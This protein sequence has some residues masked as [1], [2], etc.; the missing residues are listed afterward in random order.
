MKKSDAKP[1]S[2]FHKNKSI[3]PGIDVMKDEEKSKEHLIAELEDMRK[4]IAAW[5]K[6]GEEG[7]GEEGPLQKSE[8]EFREFFMNSPIHRF[9]L[10]D[11]DLNIIAGNKI[12]LN[13]F[14]EIFG[15]ARECFTGKSF[16]DLIPGFRTSDRH[17]NYLKV[18]TTN[19][20][21]YTDELASPPIAG[22]LRLS[23]SV[24][25]A[26]DGLGIITTDITE[27]KIAEQA[28]RDS[29][30]KFRSL[31]F[32]IPGMVYRAFADWSAE[33]ISGS[34]EICGYTVKELNTKREK[35]LEVIHPEDREKVFRE[36]AELIKK[37]MHLA[38][39]YRI[40]T[41]EGDIR[42]VEDIKTSHFSD[43]GEFEA[44]DGIVLNITQRQLAEKTLKD[45]E[46][47][48]RAL[49][50][51]S[52]D[53]IFLADPGTGLILDANP[54]AEELLSLPH[55][56][57]VG[58]HQHQ[59]HPPELMTLAKDIFSRIALEADLEN[60]TE[61]IVQCANGEKKP[62]EILAQ[63]IQIDGKP[64]VYS[65]YRDITVRKQMEEEL[66]KAQRIKSLGTLAGGIAH[67]FNNVLTA[68][69]ANIS[70]ARI[71][72]DLPNDISEVLA[73]AEKASLQAKKLTQQLLSFA[74]GGAPIKKTMSISDL[75]RDT[76]AFSLSGSNVRHEFSLPE[77]LWPVDIDEGQIGQV[78]QNLTINADQAMPDGGLV[79]IQ[80]ENAVLGERE[81]FPLKAGRYVR[82]SITDQ[83][84]GIAAK[85]L[86]NIF[87]PFF[88][89]KQ[90]GSGLGLTTTFTIVNN[91]YGH[92]GV[93]SEKTKGTT[94]HVLLPASE[95]SPLPLG[96]E[97]N[98]PVKSG[99]RVL[100]IDDE[101]IVLSVTSKVLKRLGYDVESAQND[102]K[103]IKLYEKALKGKRPFDVVIM[104]LTIPGGM[105]G[106]AAIK[107][108]KSIDPDVKV[109]ISSGYSN[110]PIM[111]RFKQY[112]FSGVVTKPY[113]IEDLAKT[114]HRIM[115]GG[116]GL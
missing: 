74:K 8:K 15:I 115:T 14:S 102:T 66:R 89:T 104:D 24:F 83:G 25:K 38:Q 80:A 86:P 7:K 71:F 30:L 76:A 99:G 84:K 101:E 87:D 9:L 52:L 65:V 3:Q 105:G 75:L 5:E 92:I 85:D 11:K 114:I 46:K 6:P 50:E 106:K 70:L 116:G 90:K 10:L 107:E 63:V 49:F 40:I 78:I 42:W 13:L 53:A 51:G 4:R 18:L 39:K 35:W 32:N 110:D 68:I 91:H 12:L 29:E 2:L 112:G 16:P 77:D 97:E 72:S 20:P 64:T 41:K 45:N 96:Q 60:L 111:S 108:L 93:E 55:E 48:F 19:T 47:R 43:Q 56:K 27:Q 79:R 17:E 67:D 61:A 59:V 94:F 103:G 34:E 69:L 33:I 88:S 54:A 113:Q 28:L 1:E 81:G 22:D 44:I 57:V 23:V 100:L 73:D 62:V 82:I 26:G 21:Y 36:G 58:L 95:K 37:K 109:I 31:V 98:R